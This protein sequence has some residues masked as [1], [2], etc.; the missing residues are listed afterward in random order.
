[1]TRCC[2]VVQNG[3]RAASPETASLR[4][5]LQI[6]VTHQTSALG[7]KMGMS[8]GALHLTDGFPMSYPLL[9]IFDYL[10]GLILVDSRTYI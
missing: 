2:E 8:I 5:R 1:M 10:S 3:A 4:L 9:D 7:H 6:H